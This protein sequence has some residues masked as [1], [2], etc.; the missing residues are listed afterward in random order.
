M[1]WVIFACYFYACAGISSKTTVLLLLLSLFSPSL[2]HAVCPAALTAKAAT[3]AIDNKRRAPS[4][5]PSSLALSPSPSSFVTFHVSFYEWRQRRRSRRKQTTKKHK[6]H[7][8][9]CKINERRGECG[10]RN[11]TKSSKIHK[12]Q[13]TKIKSA[14]TLLSLFLYRSLRLVLHLRLVACA[15]RHDTTTVN[16]I[17][18]WFMNRRRVVFTFFRFCFCCCCWE[19]Q[20]TSS[21]NKVPKKFYDCIF[22][23]ALFTHSINLCVFFI[24]PFYYLRR[25]FL[26]CVMRVCVCLFVISYDTIP[27]RLANP[28]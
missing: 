9:I 24:I 26:L 7:F 23:D 3:T 2:M 13:M 20:T 6:A 18:S 15:L 1:N 11:E 12:N 8:Y 28:I 27:N 4:T 16:F 17:H 10:A 22:C 19:F 21:S 5:S 25:L 14:F